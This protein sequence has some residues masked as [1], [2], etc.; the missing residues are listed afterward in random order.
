MLSIRSQLRG[1][2]EYYIIQSNSSSRPG[3]GRMEVGKGLLTHHMPTWKSWCHQG[4]DVNNFLSFCVETN[5]VLAHLKYLQANTYC[6]PN[7]YILLG[8]EMEVMKLNNE[9]DLL[10]VS[11]EKT[12]LWWRQRRA[13]IIQKGQKKRHCKWWVWG[14]RMEV[15]SKNF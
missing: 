6:A 2:K 7:R 8:W 9:Q 3:W 13:E 1:K 4:H 12:V 10:S 11:K 14:L 5:A 15:A